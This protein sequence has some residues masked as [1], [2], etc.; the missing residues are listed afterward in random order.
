MAIQIGVAGFDGLGYMKAITKA[1]RMGLGCVEVAFTYGVRMKPEEA[2]VMGL[3]ARKKGIALSVHAPYY[4]NLAADD[5][6][7]LT[8]SKERILASF[9]G[10]EYGPK[11]ERRHLKTTPRFFMP[12]AEALVGPNVEATLISESTDPYRDAVMMKRVVGELMPGSPV[13]PSART[14][15]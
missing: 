9:S 3:L 8:A 4:I 14:S 1:A 15:T 7:K 5:P 2:E 13:R 11:G 12:L 10:I 6:E